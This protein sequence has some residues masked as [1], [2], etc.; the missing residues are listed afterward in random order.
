LSAIV[1]RIIN[2]Q[3]II[4]IS[5]T[6]VIQTYRYAQM[7]FQQMTLAYFGNA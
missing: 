3:F 5:Y 4:V 2:I 1:I 7:N 6:S